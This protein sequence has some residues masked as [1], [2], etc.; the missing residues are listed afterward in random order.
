MGASRKGAV[1]GVGNALV[2]ILVYEDDA[3]LSKT[4]AAKGGMTLVDQSFIEKTLAMT[5]AAPAVVPGGSACNTAVGVGKLGGTARFMGK[6]GQDDLAA[7][8]EDGLKK[9]NVQPQ[10]FKSSSPTG[11]RQARGTS[12]SSDARSARRQS[13]IGN[14]AGTSSR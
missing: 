11:R 10:L 3:F 8:F 14:F 6:C 13:P 12:H 7:I 2:D 4:N 1:A 5:S 9:N